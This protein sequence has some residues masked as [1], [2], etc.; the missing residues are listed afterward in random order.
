[1]IA[2]EEEGSIKEKQYTDG[3]DRIDL[4]I[5]CEEESKEEESNQGMS[6]NRNIASKEIALTETGQKLGE[7]SADIVTSEEDGFIKEKQCSDSIMSEGTAHRGNSDDQIDLSIVC[8]EE[9]KE[10][11]SNQDE[12]L[13]RSF[14][15]TETDQ[16]IAEPSVDIPAFE[17]E[18]SFREK[19]FSHSVLSEGT[20]HKESTAGQTDLSIVCEEESKEESSQEEGLSR[21]VVS[22]ETQ[23]DQNLGKPSA[24]IVAFEEDGSI[25]EKQCT[26]SVVSQGTAHQ[27]SRAD[28]ID[29]SMEEESSQEESLNRNIV[30]EETGTDQNLGEPSVDIIASEEE[31]SI[32]EKPCTDSVVSEGSGTAHQETR[33]D[34]ID[35]SIVCEE[36]S[37]EEE[38]NQSLNR[39]TVS[40]ETETTFA[41]IDQNLGEPSADIA[42]SEEEGLVKEKQDIDSALS[43]GTAHQESRTDQIDL[44]IVCE[45]NSK[46]EKSNQEEILD[47]NI[48][49]EEAETTFETDQSFGEPSANIVAS[50]E[51]GS[52]EKQCADGVVNEDTVHLQNGQDQIDL[53]IACE[54]DKKSCTASEHNLREPIEHG[55]NLAE[56]SVQ[57]KIHE[58]DDA[59][60]SQE[61]QRI[62]LLKSEV[63]THG[64]GDPQVIDVITDKDKCQGGEPDRHTD[65]SI[66]L[67]ADPAEC[68]AGNLQEDHEVKDNIHDFQRCIQQE[69]ECIS[70]SSVSDEHLRTILENSVTKIE[71]G[72][73]QVGEDILDKEQK[74]SEE[75]LEQNQDERTQIGDLERKEE[76]TGEMV[77]DEECVQEPGSTSHDENVVQIED[78]MVET[79]TVHKSC[80]EVHQQIDADTPCKGHTTNTIENENAKPDEE[81]LEVDEIQQEREI[82]V[83]TEPEQAHVKL[84]FCE[85]TV[86]EPTE[87]ETGKLDVET[88]C[89][90]SIKEQEIHIHEN[91]QQLLHAGKET[92]ETSIENLFGREGSVPESTDLDTEDS[93]VQSDDF[94]TEE[95]TRNAIGAM[96]HDLD[97]NDEIVE[98]HDVCTQEH[99]NLEVDTDGQEHKQSP[100]ENQEIS[101]SVETGEEQLEADGSGAE[102]ITMQ[103]KQEDQVHMMVQIHGMKTETTQQ[104]DDKVGDHVENWSRQAELN[105]MQTRNDDIEQSDYHTEKDIKELNIGKPPTESIIYDIA[106]HEDSN[107]QNDVESN[108]KTQHDSDYLDEPNMGK[109][110][111]AQVIGG[112]IEG[113]QEEDDDNVLEGYKQTGSTSESEKLELEIKELEA[114]CAT[115]EPYQS[116]EVPPC[117]K[118]PLVELKEEEQQGKIDNTEEEK[119]CQEHYLS[120]IQKEYE[121]HTSTIESNQENLRMR[122]L[123][124]KNVEIDTMNTQK[125]PCQI[126]D[127]P[128][129]LL[130]NP[131][132]KLQLA[133]PECNVNL[134]K[135]DHFEDCG[136][137]VTRSIEDEIK[138]EAAEIKITGYS[139]EKLDQSDNSPTYVQQAT[140][141]AEYEIQTPEVKD[142]V[143]HLVLSN[144][145]EQQ[146]PDEDWHGNECEQSIKVCENDSPDLFDIN[147]DN[148]EQK[149]CY[150][151]RASKEQSGEVQEGIFLD[152][153]KDEHNEECDQ[154]QSTTALEENAHGS[155]D[156]A[157]NKLEVKHQEPAATE[158]SEKRKDSQDYVSDSIDKMNMHEI[159]NLDAIRL[160]ESEERDK[161]PDGLENEKDT[162]IRISELIMLNKLEVDDALL[163]Q[164]KEYKPE[165][166]DHGPVESSRHIDRNNI[167]DSEENQAVELGME[168]PDISHYEGK[169]PGIKIPEKAVA[170]C[171]AVEEGE[172][173]QEGYA[174][175]DDNGHATKDNIAE[176]AKNEREEPL[177]EWG[178][179]D[180]DAQAS[181]PTI[182]KKP[183]FEAIS[184]EQNE[185][186]GQE[187]DDCGQI[188]HIGILERKST[189]ESAEIEADEPKR[190]EL[191]NVEQCETKTPA[192]VIQ[193]KSERE[194]IMTEENGETRDESDQVECGKL[195][196]EMQIME[197]VVDEPRKYEVER[198]TAQLDNVLAETGS[199]EGKPENRSDTQVDEI[200][201]S[202]ANKHESGGIYEEKRCLAGITDIGDGE[203]QEFKVL[204]TEAVTP[205]KIESQKEN[206]AI[207]ELISYTPADT[208]NTNPPLIDETEHHP[209][210]PEKILSDNA[211]EMVGKFP[212]EAE[213]I[214][215]AEARPQPE[216]E[217]KQVEAAQ[218]PL[219]KN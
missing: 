171:T 182:L 207:D 157:M 106:T 36:S 170:E 12:R 27:E 82:N 137:Q 139:D 92:T 1:M 64:A 16:Y 94:C 71:K 132:D 60:A 30:S 123:D 131:S 83:Q 23:T 210:K 68:I 198:S 52:I 167:A 219:M 206:L 121:P 93:K 31:E 141:P 187:R 48:V 103:E 130:E 163:E 213:V 10:E 110:G 159:D 40:K 216:A 4:S 196:G 84:V 191:P 76:C 156:D 11:E 72:E 122:E 205:D 136:E 29:L 7:L 169:M 199:Q 160:E 125:G 49:R 217:A 3:V 143:L 34:Q 112:E 193:E 168:V 145:E 176:S 120:S 62:S 47:R 19:Q 180:T 28:E 148:K 116:H 79:V 57:E 21:N 111:V 97:T 90:T 142:P 153:R 158:A 197:H 146:K 118:E 194:Y 161:T 189:A 164:N 214:I 129:K 127:D 65:K 202:E 101:M 8:E 102:S 61:E 32:K 135:V 192:V 128:E 124:A 208:T 80:Q 74:C 152:E 151:E 14:I 109:K 86:D 113:A 87:N 95:E 45:E 201:E 178:K 26:D 75:I 188:E 195:E 42:A 17:E 200:M 35:M 185:E 204:Q 81:D 166:N 77:D 144:I 70:I 172:K 183:G 150:T 154:M 215:V 63:D 58:D 115:V 88:P 56:E 181:E 59:G 46:I 212:A 108:I 140:T 24:D 89:V 107:I 174:N 53:S 15:S 43:E 78:P 2:S 126:N 5:V 155:L 39:N 22:E 44:S 55:I 114:E 162:E 73:P 209:E 20:A 67:D 186:C 133:E 38:S 104:E 100:D 149:I 175:S 91:C 173:C 85:D 9:S 117:Q 98:E 54:E 69:P 66:V 165:D 211:K 147:F 50:E 179:Q 99:L 25:K 134:S 119:P 184:F 190:M 203:K 96:K 138:R 33:A 177:D 41:E 13:E 105:Q 51:E 37:R 218:Q 6:L 18:G